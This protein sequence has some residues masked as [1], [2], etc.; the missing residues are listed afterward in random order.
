MCL[1]LDKEA[2]TEAADRIRVYC[3]L[4]LRWAGRTSLVSAR[5]QPWIAS[6]HVLPAL[7]LRST[8]R[9]VCHDRIADV[10][11]GAGFPGL[12]LAVTLPEARFF[13]VESRRRRA[14]FLRHAVRSLGLQN[15]ETIHGRVEQWR[16]HLPMD[17]ILSRAVTSLDHLQQLTTR[18]LAPHGLLLITLPPPGSAPQPQVDTTAAAGRV[19]IDDRCHLLT[20]PVVT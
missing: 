8:V 15:V 9:S 13:L 4:L 3:D 7:S 18:C 19:C 2:R 17:L 14:S 5:D 11:S 20:R 10:G 16:P 6:R 12:P 1:D